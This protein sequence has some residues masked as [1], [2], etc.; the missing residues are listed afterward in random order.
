MT[1]LDNLLGPGSIVFGVSA[2]DKKALFRFIANRA[3]EIA[4]ADPQTVL[5]ELEKRERLG[6]TG[7]GEGIAIP[8]GR[9]DTLERPF[10]LFIRLAQP[11]DFDSADNMPVDCVFAVFSPEED[12]AAHL[13]ALAQVSRSMRD[14]ELIAKLRGARSEDALFALLTTIEAASAA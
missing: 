1:V 10:G 9:I 4:N 6:S 12:G 2:N 13:Q 14:R 8:H 11:V 3:A 5:D 7:F